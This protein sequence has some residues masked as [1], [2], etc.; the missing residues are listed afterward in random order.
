MMKR[1]N[2]DNEKAGTFSSMMASRSE[3]S[4]IDLSVDD[5]NRVLTTTVKTVASGLGMLK[6]NN[7][8]IKFNTNK[9]WFDSE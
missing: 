4:F 9:P 3:V 1:L 7:F 2:F 5:M 6:C 8:S